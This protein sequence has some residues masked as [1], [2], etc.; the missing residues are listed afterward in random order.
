MILYKIISLIN[1]LMGAYAFARMINLIRKHD[2]PNRVWE[3]AFGM[4]MV[5]VLLATFNQVYTFFSPSSNL[6]WP[7]KMSVTFLFIFAYVFCTGLRS[8]SPLRKT[9][10]NNTGSI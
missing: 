3:F 7:L 10:G 5:A 4:L 1:L 8:I 2:P 6:G 9:D